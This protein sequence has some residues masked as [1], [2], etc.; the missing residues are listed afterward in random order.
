MIPDEIKKDP[1]AEFYE[2]IK[3]VVGHLTKHGWYYWNGVTVPLWYGTG[4]Y[5]FELSMERI[6]VPHMDDLSV[7]DDT[8][9]Y[10]LAIYGDPNNS[11]DSWEPLITRASLRDCLKVFKVKLVELA[12]KGEKVSPKITDDD[13]YAAMGSIL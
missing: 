10:S 8:I 6:K 5:F 7:S 9:R 2:R 13:V 1:N 11:F 3:K 12:L 4:P